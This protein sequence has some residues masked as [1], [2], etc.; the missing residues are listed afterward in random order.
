MSEP[1]PSQS[2]PE[3]IGKKSEK[4]NDEK[5]LRSFTIR[6]EEA[7]IRNLERVGQ[8]TRDDKIARI[9]RNYLRLADVF[10]T[11]GNRMVGHDG[12]DLALIP[13]DML[14]TLIRRTVGEDVNAQ[15]DLGNE[16]GKYLKNIFYHDPRETV[17]QKVDFIRRLGWFNA[18]KDPATKQVLIPTEFAPELFIQA[19]IYQITV[20]KELPKPLQKGGKE[21]EKDFQKRQ[22]VREETIKKDRMTLTKNV[23]NEIGFDAFSFE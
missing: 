7:A 4:K 20:K 3:E 16:F 2:N 10:A 1:I 5:N 13:V 22:A 12:K 9:A 11:D 6:V 8:Q 19:M 18:K 17:T 23:E 14:R 15:I 21:G